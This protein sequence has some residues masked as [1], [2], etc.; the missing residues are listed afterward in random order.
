MQNFSAIKNTTIELNEASKSSIPTG[1][2]VFLL[3]LNIL[4]SITASLGNALI[5]VALHK[6]TSLHPPTKL[7]YRCLAITDL[8]VGVIIHP[9]TVI[10]NLSSVTT[11]ISWKMFYYIDKLQ[12]TS[13]FVLCQVSVLTPCAISVDR[14]LALLSGLRYRHV[15]TLPRIRAVIACFWLIGISAGSIY[16][17]NISTAFIVGFVDTLFSVTTSAFSY[18]KIFRELRNQLQVHVV[19]QGLTNW[20][21]A[22]LNIARYKRSVTSAIWVQFAILTCYTPFFVVVMIMIYG[23]MSSGK[24]QIAFEITATLT[25]FNSTLNPILYCWRI[26]SVRQAAKD[27]IKQIQFCKS[28][29][30]RPVNF[31]GWRTDSQALNVKNCKE[32]TQKG[33]CSSS[34][35]NKVH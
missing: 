30:V 29:S 24:F 6:E 22:P 25:Y 10:F 34:K 35:E 11:V 21:Q 33:A 1:I 23:G 15:V 7:L 14:L 18:R 16:L 20:R 27:T 17:W 12:K 8:C 4:L 3:A 28:A 26:R 13:S 9:V 32:L 31:I 19:P 5:L 2:A